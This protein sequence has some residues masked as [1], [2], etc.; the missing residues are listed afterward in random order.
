MILRKKNENMQDVEQ[1]L[2]T[3]KY[4]EMWKEQKNK[5]W[6]KVINKKNRLD[7]KC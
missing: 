5:K 6:R 3:R 4:A 7:K 2:I 1:K